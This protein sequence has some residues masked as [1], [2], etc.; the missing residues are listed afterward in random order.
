[1]REEKKCERIHMRESQVWL[2][3]NTR[4]GKGW[5]TARRKGAQEN[6]LK[7]NPIAYVFIERCIRER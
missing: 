2:V 6:Y 1:M 3:K 7:G 4:R 5:Q